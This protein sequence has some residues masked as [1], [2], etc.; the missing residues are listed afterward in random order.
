MGLLFQS[1][2]ATTQILTIGHRADLGKRMWLSQCTTFHQCEKCL[3]AHVR[4]G[5]FMYEE[6]SIFVNS[7]TY[8][9]ARDA[10]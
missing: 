4:S 5:I 8:V 6:E 1:H 9:L 10:I 2:L 3:K 7:A